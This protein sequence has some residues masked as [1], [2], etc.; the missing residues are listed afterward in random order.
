MSKEI[1][2]R[3]VQM[4]FDNKNFENNVKT[5]MTT[6][7]KLKQSLNFGSASKGLDGLAIA[8]KN[9]GSDKGLGVV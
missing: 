7:D 5:S 3:V 6:L 9:L 8:S 1:D 2:Q 4:E